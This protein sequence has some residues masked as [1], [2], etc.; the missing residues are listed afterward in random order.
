[1]DVD[2]GDIIQDRAV[3]DV[4]DNNSCLIQKLLFTDE[5]SNSDKVTVSNLKKHI[6]Y[7]KTL[8]D[9]W[10]DELERRKELKL[11]E[12][13]F[14]KIS[15]QNYFELV[16]SLNVKNPQIA[17]ELI[18]KNFIKDNN[19][20]N[21]NN[22][23]NSDIYDFCIIQDRLNSLIQ[24]E[25]KSNLKK[26][27]GGWYKRI[28]FIRHDYR[29]T[30][31][32]DE[33]VDTNDE[34]L[35]ISEISL[36]NQTRHRLKE[37]MSL[38]R[39]EDCYSKVGK[40]AAAEENI[41]SEKKNFEEKNYK[42]LSTKVKKAKVNIS[43]V[44]ISAELFQTLF[45]NF[46]LFRKTFPNSLAIYE[47]IKYNFLNSFIMSKFQ[48]HLFYSNGKDFLDFV[49]S[50]KAKKY[51]TNKN[52]L[53]DNKLLNNHIGL[54][55][56][57]KSYNQVKANPEL[58]IS[59]SIKE[60]NFEIENYV[61]EWKNITDLKI[62]Y[63]KLGF[64]KTLKQRNLIFQPKN[65]KIPTKNEIQ[66]K[67]QKIS[68]KKSLINELDR[69]YFTHKFKCIQFPELKPSNNFLAL[70]YK[71]EI[72]PST[73]N[74]N[75]FFETTNM[76]ISKNVADEIKNKFRIL[77]DE[78][79][80]LKNL[81]QISNMTVLS[82]EIF[83]KTNENKVWNYDTDEIIAVCCSL[84]DENTKATKQEKYN[85]YNFIITS[86][87]NRNIAKRYKTNKFI[88]GPEYTGFKNNEFDFTNLFEIFFVKDEY[89]I[90]FKLIEI[91]EQYD[92]D[93]IIGYDAELYSLGYIVRRATALGMDL[94]YLLSRQVCWKV[95]Y[96][97]ENVKSEITK[98]R[99]EYNSR[100]KAEP[101]N[102]PN[103]LKYME[104]KF[105]KKIKILGRVVISLC[106]LMEGELKLTNYKLENV[107]F[108]VLKIREPEIKHFFLYSMY[109]SGNLNQITYSLY[110]YAKRARYNL[111]LMETL[112]FI[113]KDVQFTKSKII[114]I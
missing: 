2:V 19:L 79:E 41:L 106:K 55:F 15:D 33:E 14:E 47:R 85:F 82:L 51:G 61:K 100:K 94:R 75:K 103:E 60:R 70:N 6:N 113:N 57:L 50:N 35:S 63:N 5:A 87:D 23:D 64:L 42:L 101:I 92:P 17:K 12:M 48:S 90:L 112:D 29:E 105:G 3:K 37:G 77:S 49:L 36:N 20:C 98:K 7:T 110:Y 71:N 8:I 111:L 18:S 24:Y 27:F 96:D 54:S 72:S 74:K 28:N 83:C 22:S 31:N 30:N 58:N 32:K 34:T 73:E 80:L 16:Q 84:H 69:N 86:Q 1:L 46:H 21:P 88:I 78:K 38:K 95:N 93:V 97:D 107:V 66:N 44:E 62:G 114:L 40:D 102:S 67:L 9:L 99:F 104:Q 65:L 89:G 76:K 13:R 91:F 43:F 10:D 26:K 68:T 39:I 52:R 109:T 56:Y 4:K 59:K 108:H 45:K 81:E 11:E 53:A 25:N